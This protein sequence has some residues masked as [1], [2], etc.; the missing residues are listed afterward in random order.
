MA[1]TRT[2][3]GGELLVELRR[4]DPTPLHRQLE[5]ELRAAIRTGRLDADAALPS[6]RAL[7][8]QLDLSRGV[9]VEA[10]EQLI[11][12]G[13]L[14]STRGGA[15]RVAGNVAPSST[16]TTGRRPP[17]PGSPESPRIDFGYGRPDVTQFPRQAWMRSVRRVMNEAPSDRFGYLD[18]RGAPELREALATYLNR[19]RGT[20]AVPDDVVVCNGFA[21]AL[22]LFVQ[23]IREDGEGSVAGEDPGFNDLRLA[24]ADNGLDVV[25]VPVDDHGID[26]AALAR[27]AVR[28]VVVTPAHHFPTGAVLTAE[29]RAALIAWANDR[30][31]LILEDDYDAEYRYDREPIGALHGLAPERVVYAGSA[32]KTLAP[33]LRLGW[34]LVPPRLVDRI[35]L[36]K[37]HVDRG[38]P[39]LEQLTFAD[40]LARGEF[41]LHLRRMRPVYRARRDAL[42]DAIRRYLP[43]M[44]PVG[45]SAGLHVFAWLPNGVDAAAVARR[46]GAA[47]VLVYELGRYGYARSGGPGGLIFG[48]GG[49]GESEIVEG[50]RIVADAL[51]A[52]L[53]QAPPQASAG[54]AAVADR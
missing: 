49:V 35:A 6:S 37:E 38:S 27:T 18:L 13:Y 10:Y 41:D 22:R 14:A 28:A 26:V 46:A 24:G 52:E 9:V 30:D 8:D 36:T 31:A 17:P 20:S 15:T 44:R 39:S 23:T 4:D 48:Y 5:R 53:G 45:A 43:E 40:F 47:G 3:S 50:V 16:E 32:S 25:P 7:A 42:L 2:S 11:A 12:E 54:L 33:G 29:R 34:M 1:R 21:Q 19:V 51:A